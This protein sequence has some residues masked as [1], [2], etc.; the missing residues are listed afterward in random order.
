M[1]KVKIKP[2]QFLRSALYGC[3]WSDSPRGRFILG[4]RAHST[5]KTQCWADPIADLKDY[6]ISH[7]CSS[8]ILLSLYQP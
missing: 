8:C 5:H 4:E 6:E 3:K 2:Y 1:G 7:D